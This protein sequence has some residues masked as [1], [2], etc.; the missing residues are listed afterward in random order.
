M[1]DWFCF[2]KQCCSDEML[3]SAAFHLGLHCLPVVLIQVFSRFQGA[4]DVIQ[5]IFYCCLELGA[6]NLDSNGTDI[7]RI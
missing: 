1:P 6:K 7:G 3:H 2:R 4:E 5:N